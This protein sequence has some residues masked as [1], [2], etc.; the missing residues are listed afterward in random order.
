MKSRSSFNLSAFSSKKDVKFSMLIVAWN[1]N[2]SCVCFSFDL[3]QPVHSSF[4][5]FAQSG[6]TITT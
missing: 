2:E 4:S 5:S 3:E 6:V 1:G